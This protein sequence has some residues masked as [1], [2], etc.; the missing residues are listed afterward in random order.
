M[1]APKPNGQTPFTTGA[2]AGTHVSTH[3]GAIGASRAT[4]KLSTMSSTG[5]H[6]LG[7]VDA[8]GGLLGHGIKTILP[9]QWFFG[10]GTGT[11]RTLLGS[12]VAITLWNQ[13]H[14]C[15]GMCHYL[16]PGRKRTPGAPLDG[17]FGDEALEMMVARLSAKGTRSVDYIAHLYGGADTLPD[18]VNLTGGVKPNIGERNIELGWSLIDRY[19]F[20]LEG[21]DVGDAVPRT[22]TL[23]LAHG[24]VEVRRS[25]AVV[26]QKIEATQLYHER[27][28]RIHR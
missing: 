25:A 12:C 1:W 28:H 17:R 4:S 7:H 3:T 5:S 9:G 19:G 22:V 11:L 18:E 2:R 15:G 27:H 14:H 20:Q 26:T 8:A 10:A 23:D 21:I 24:T 6:H 16:L 13:R